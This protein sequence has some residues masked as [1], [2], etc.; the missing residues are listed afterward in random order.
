MMTTNNNQYRA[1]RLLRHTRYPTYQLHAAMSSKK[2]SL[3]DGL[4]IAVLTVME[5]LRHRI[6]S[7]I[8]AG[9]QLPPPGGF[10]DVP[11]TAFVSQHY[12]CGYVLDIVSMLEQGIWSMQIVEPDLG[13]DPGNPDQEREPVAGRVIGANIGW[14]LSGSWRQTRHLA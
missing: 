6:A 3:E 10:Q 13:S 5:W 14:Q 8:P 9:L 2:T 7:D 12:N 4:K 11:A 1:I